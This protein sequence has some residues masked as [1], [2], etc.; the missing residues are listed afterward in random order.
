MQSTTESIATGVVGGVLTTA[1]LFIISRFL[2]TV[3][4][5]WYRTLVYRGVDISGKWKNELAFN[6]GRTQTLLA[7]IY[8]KAHAIT[9]TLTIVKSK[10]GKTLDTKKLRLSGELKDR[11]LL[12][13]LH[14]TSNTEVAA[15][16]L[17]LEIVGDG[18]T[19]SGFTAWYDAGAGGVH[20]R[21]VVW[22]RAS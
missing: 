5:P 15:V 21:Q 9:G 1:L 3:V 7:D 16:N 4:F 13:T 10:N 14:P 22:S 17:L 8:Q 12:C 6:E 11:L 19:M 20:G 2:E 18:S